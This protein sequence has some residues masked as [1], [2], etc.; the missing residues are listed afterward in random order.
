MALI[1]PVK[2]LKRSTPAPEDL[3][4]SGQPL[5]ISHPFYFGFLAAAGALVS[6]TMLRAL[7]S[8]SQVFV[9]ILLSLF[10]AAGLNP[11]VEL[12]RRWGLTRTWAVSAI[13]GIVLIFVSLFAWVVIPP[14][15]HQVNALLANAPD[16]V[17][18]LKHNSL[19]NRLNENYG[20]VDSLQKK[21]SETIKN[22]QF[23]VTAFGGVLGVGRAVVSGAI[24][25]LT[26]LVLTLYF[27]ASL[28]KVTTVVYR[29]VPASRRVR[30]A[31]LSDA[32]IFRV[33]V[34]VGGQA[35]V[36]VIAGIFA[37]ILGYAIGIPYATAMAMLVFICGLIPL[38]GHILG[39][40]VMTL[41]AFTKSPTTAIIAFV[42][43]VIYIQIENYLIMPRIM[44]QTLAVPGLVTI[45]A[46]LLG[47]SLLGLIG[48]I[49]AVPIAAA[50]LL[51]LDEVVYP[52][53]DQS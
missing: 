3:G 2:K 37:L 53:T 38:I 27:L 20:V 15:V 10:L 19:I 13:V 45:L 33:G 42:F 34:F 6:I 5:D 23:V 14:V 18:N 43:Y 46:A 50:I 31:R 48:A 22:G 36:S 52:K 17:S 12:F 24:A 49:M 44:K 25:T 28:P 51:I 39:V 11:A 26:V 47:T 35:I 32:I 1:K 21:V 41:I 40:T 16:I 8:A 29:M 30:V 7:A 4:S 9:L